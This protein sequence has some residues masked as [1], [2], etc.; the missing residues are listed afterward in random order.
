MPRLPINYSNTIIYKLVC[1]D[2]EITDVYVGH[3]TD[4]TNRKRQHKGTCNN[5]N[6]KDYNLY[7]Y[8]FI[9]ENG[10]WENWSMLEI[11]K[12]SCVDKQDALRNE[13]KYIEELKATLN[14]VIPTRTPKER[15]DQ[16][17]DQILEYHKEYQ[18]H[19]REQIAE[20]QKE[21]R[22]QH[23]D[24][25]IEYHHEYYEQNRVKLLEKQKTKIICECG[26]TYSHGDRARHFR[27][28]KHIQSINI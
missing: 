12:L 25:N 16:N 6:V 23:R 1:N 9:R 11:C 3:T 21:Y 27:T 10:G 7:V 2:V 19:H 4:F 20:Y 18:E 22:H 5:E 15:Y 24:Q 17:R 26:A 13:R 28:K 14:K 8:Q